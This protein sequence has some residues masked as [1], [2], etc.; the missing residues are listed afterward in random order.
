MDAYAQY[1]RSRR[2]R[3]LGL[4]NRRLAAMLGDFVYET[5]SAEDESR[6]YLEMLHD[7]GKQVLTGRDLD[8]L[9]RFTSEHNREERRAVGMEEE[10]FSWG[11]VD[12]LSQKIIR[13]VSEAVARAEPEFTENFAA[14]DRMFATTNALRE[15]R[16]QVAHRTPSDDGGRLHFYRQSDSPVTPRAIWGWTE[17]AASYWS[18]LTAI[19]NAISMA[20]GIVT[21]PWIMTRDPRPL[22]WPPAG[23]SIHGLR[24]IER[25]GISVPEQRLKNARSEWTTVTR[26]WKVQRR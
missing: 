15:F 9:E 18:N 3:P 25:S 20:T 14:L 17:V 6:R 21:G 2:T 23:I 19:T 22:Q 8:S 24:V 1:A 12:R 26:R 16:N 5:S 10:Y 7:K 4:S 13:T 11:R